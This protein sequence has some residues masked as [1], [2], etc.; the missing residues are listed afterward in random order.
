MYKIIGADGKE[1][2]PISA[3]QLRQWLNEDRD[4]QRGALVTSDLLGFPAAVAEP[5]CER[6][7]KKTGLERGR[8]AAGWPWPPPRAT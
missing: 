7:T 4:G 8:T 1:Y 2:G 6:I 3:E 5:I